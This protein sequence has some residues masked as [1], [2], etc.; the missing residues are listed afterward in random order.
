MT[1]TLLLLTW[2]LAADAPAP[3]PAPAPAPV[4]VAAPVHD[5]GAGCAG[6]GGGFGG[7]C[8]TGVCAGG[9]DPNPMEKTGLFARLKAKLKK[10]FTGL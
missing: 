6:C 8:A 7:S 4:V 5:L 1:P 10:P 2:T 3:M 9:Q